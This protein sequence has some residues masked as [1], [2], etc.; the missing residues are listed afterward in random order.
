M[1]FMRVEYLYFHM[2][3]FKLNGVLGF[4]GF[5]VLVVYVLMNRYAT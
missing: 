3:K 5:G 1:R 4:W 2:I